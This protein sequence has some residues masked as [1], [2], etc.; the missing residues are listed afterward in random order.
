MSRSTESNGQVGAHLGQEV[1]ALGQSL[2]PWRSCGLFPCQGSFPG[3]LG[4]AVLCCAVR[5]GCPTWPR[6]LACPPPPSQVLPLS[7][8]MLH[9]LLKSSLALE[10]D[11]TGVWCKR[12]S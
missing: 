2:C 9:Q 7:D 4:C 3:T 6:L 5:S 1:L 11:A 8:G 12:I 10:I